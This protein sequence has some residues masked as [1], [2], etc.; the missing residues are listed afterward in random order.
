MGNGNERLDCVDANL[1]ASEEK[2]QKLKAELA[3][4]KRLLDMVKCPNCDGSGSTLHQVSSRQY[5]SRDMAMDAG[6][7]EQE[8]S[9]YSDDEWEQE[10]CQW[11]A[12]KNQLSEDKDSE[13]TKHKEALDNLKSVLCDPEG[14]VCVEGTDEDRTII[15]E[16]LKE[17]ETW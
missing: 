9:L 1:A 5:V 7:P 13:E 17:L 2:V 4:A 3:L 16:A 15:Q 14:K 10:Q 11:C 8:G 6:M 12:E